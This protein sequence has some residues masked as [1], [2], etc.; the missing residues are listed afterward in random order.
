M[1]S[2]SDGLVSWSGRGR[3]GGGAKIFTREGGDNFYKNGKTTVTASSTRKSRFLPQLYLHF[4]FTTPDQ[5]VQILR[6]R[7]ILQ[8]YLWR[9]CFEMF[10]HHKLFV[11]KLGM[12]VLTRFTA[13]R[14]PPKNARMILKS[15]LFY[16]LLMPSTSTR[17]NRT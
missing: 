1:N 14:G 13:F 4:F 10:H 17:N 5:L 3:G 7:R 2:K 11:M 8:F 16:L 6:I 15:R 9:S 12:L